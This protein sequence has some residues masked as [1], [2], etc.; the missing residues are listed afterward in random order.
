MKY[1]INLY[2]RDGMSKEAQIVDL[3][4]WQVGQFLAQRVADGHHGAT[5]EPSGSHP[6]GSIKWREGWW[7]PVG[8]D[9]RA[10]IQSTYLS[11]V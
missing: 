3:E 2:G 8:S 11:I 1:V 9:L 5:A 4:R 7:P 6:A 10:V